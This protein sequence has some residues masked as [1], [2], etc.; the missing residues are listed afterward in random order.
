MKKVTLN[1]LVYFYLRNPVTGETM[2]ELP[3]PQEQT[4]YVV[5]EQ[6]YADRTTLV[7]Y[8]DKD[9]SLWRVVEYTTGNNMA[10]EPQPTREEAIKAVCDFL[11]DTDKDVEDFLKV[12][13][14]CEVLNQPLV[15]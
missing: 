1:V 6:P 8:Q 15:E 2:L 11:N 4:G 13:A 7:V 5:E 12:I 10:I 14:E 9:S 3:L